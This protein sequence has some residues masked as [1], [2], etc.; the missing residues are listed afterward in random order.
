[1]SGFWSI[2]VF[3]GAILAS[4]AI[5]LAFVLPPLLRRTAAAGAVDRR[6]VNIAI[7]QDQLKELA[8]DVKG[9]ELTQDQFDIARIEIEKRMSEDVPAADASPAASEK[10]RWAGVVVAVAI[11]LAALAGYAVF[12]SPAALMAPEASA[13]QADGRHDPTAM[14]AVLEDKL[15]KNPDNAAGWY[16]LGRSYAALQRFPDAAKALEKAVSLKPDD[17]DVLADYADVL[18]VVQGGN[19]QGKPLEFIGKAL[20]IDA[21]HIKALNLAGNAAYQRGDFPAA[22]RYWRELL[23]Q[24]AQDAAATKEIEDAIQDAQKAGGGGGGLD[25]LSAMAAPEGSPPQDAKAANSAGAISGTVSLAA[26]LRGQVSPGDTV[27]IVAVAQQG[28]KM[29]LAGMKLTVADLPYRFTLD[30]A[31]AMTPAAKLSDYPA[32]VV[33]ARVSKSGQA[34]PQSGDFEG[35]AGPVEVGGKKSVDVVIDSLVP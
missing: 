15:K 9:G 7:Y 28:P 11:P 2:S 27:F 3:W 26:K 32:V 4:I 30:D 13:T 8:D 19:L 33:R 23:P 22:I 31:S 14:L 34:M 24:V 5:A 25:N 21:R 16:M 12:G 20:Q 35:H 10:G 1:M 29:P 6:S 17:P 18:A